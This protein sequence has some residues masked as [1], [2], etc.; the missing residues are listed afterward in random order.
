MMAGNGADL[1][2]RFGNQLSFGMRR[3]E[4]GL[5]QSRNMLDSIDPIPADVVEA[6]IGV[7]VNALTS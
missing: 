3:V 4:N 1:M 7:A 5:Q 6:A 2:A